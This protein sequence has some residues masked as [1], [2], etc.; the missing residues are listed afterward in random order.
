MGDV[1]TGMISGFLAQGF[2]PSEAAIAGVY[3][4]GLCGDILAGKRGAFGFVASDIIRIIP[5]TIHGKI[6]V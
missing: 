6:F 1:L 2:E 3:I 4:H 5:E